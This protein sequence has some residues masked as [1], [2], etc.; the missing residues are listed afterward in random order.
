MNTKTNPIQ[1][2]AASVYVS[3]HSDPDENRYLFAYTIIIKNAGDVTA[4]LKT[5]H[6]IITDSNGKTEEVRGEGVVG[7]QPTLAP[8]EEFTYTSAAVIE[9]PVGAMHGS[10]QMVSS[11][12]EHFDAE[13]PAFSL[14]VPNTVY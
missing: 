6:W 12:G 10:Y 13:I 11:T 8:G 1:V 2:S 14:A 4:Q 9:T 3:Q 7:E 5:R